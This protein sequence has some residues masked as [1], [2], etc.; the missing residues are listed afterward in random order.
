MILAVTALAPPASAADSEVTFTNGGVTLHG[1]VVAPPGGT[2]LPGLVLVHGSGTHSREDYRD[3]AEAFA[4][5]GIATLIYDKRTEG[6]SQF[7]RS[8]S[9]LADDALA[10]VEA[11]RKRPDVDPARVGVWGLSEGGW[12]APL[13]A[14]RSAD[15]AFVVTLGAN[16][17]EPSRQQAW[18]IENQLRR[19]GM[20]GSI[21]RM[22]SSAML[23]QL[24]GGGVFPEARYDPVPVLKSLRQPVLG[25][26]GAKDVLTP[27]G[28]A[29]RIFQESVA[30]HTLRVFPDAQHQLRRTTDGFDKLPGYAPG[31]LELV[32][33]WVQHPPT[34]SSADAPPAQDRPSAAVT[35]LSWYEPT[36][37]Q[38]A[39][40]VLLLVAF[41]W[42]PLARRGPAAKAARWLSAT[43]LLAVLGFLAV[44]VVIQVSM[45]KGLGPVV[46]GRPLPWL[47]LQLLSL[48]A[49]AATIGTAVAWWRHRTP[50]LG[51]LLAGGVV[52][53]PWALYWGLLGI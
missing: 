2:K 45:G 28:E 37:L 1:T 29:V 49:V 20:D 39:V 50:R 25:L 6:Y 33:S 53:V 15:V 18:A 7:E 14:S 44:D 16:G 26:W 30:R 46:A 27:P 52:F 40:L 47:A 32:G 5:Q 48:G 19:L 23:R 8:Y 22:A 10:A 24:I 31:Y 43:G 17:V 3:Q 42:Y 34:V 9:T 35:P 4:R 36:W 21:V 41:A 38:L 13:A 11:L 51:V 12:V